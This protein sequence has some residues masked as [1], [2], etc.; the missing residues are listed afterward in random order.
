MFDLL[1][2][3]TSSP[4]QRF[5]REISVRDFRLFDSFL[6]RMTHAGGKRLLVSEQ[7]K[8]WQNKGTNMEEQ[9]KKSPHWQKMSDSV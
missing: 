1:S 4:N 7:R 6:A 2:V 3:P 8:Q 5:S 9:W